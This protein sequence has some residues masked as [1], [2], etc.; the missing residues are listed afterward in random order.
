L[1]PF[2]ENNPEFSVLDLKAHYRGYRY[3]GWSSQ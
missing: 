3:E 1:R 2:R